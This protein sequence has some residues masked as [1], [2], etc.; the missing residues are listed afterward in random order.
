MKEPN[1][2]HNYETEK[3]T[4]EASAMA[5]NLQYSLNVFGHLTYIGPPIYASCVMISGGKPNN[6]L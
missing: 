1:T 2:F 5:E 3:I 4:H 6:M